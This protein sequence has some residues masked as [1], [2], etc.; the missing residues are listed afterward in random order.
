MRS[1]RVVTLL[2]AAVIVIGAVAGVAYAQTMG[3]GQGGMMSMATMMDHMQQVMGETSQ[4]MDHAHGQGMMGQG[5]MPNQSGTM[6]YGHGMMSGSGEMMGM[7]NGT[8]SMA[9]TM[10]RLMQHM[11]N[12]MGNQELMKNPAF[13]EHLQQMQQ[14]MNTMMQ[15]FDRFVGDVKALQKQQ[16]SK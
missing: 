5:T 14:S 12:M 11:Q 16:T 1:R 3:M 2:G 10:N 9:H 4:M 8:D 7:V 6:S 13:A 15:G